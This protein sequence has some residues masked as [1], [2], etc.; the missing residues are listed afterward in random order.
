MIIV[1]KNAIVIN[2]LLGFKNIKIIQNKD[3]FNFSLDSVL[4]PNFAKLNK[5]TKKIVDLCTGNAPIPLILSTKTDAKITGF[6][7]QKEI[8]ELSE[9]TIKLNNLE[10]KIKIINDDIKNIFNYYKSDTVDLITCN[11]PYF[12][13][14]DQ[15]LRNENEVKTNARHETL[16]K[17]EDI[18]IISRKLLKNGSPLVMVHRTERL[19]EI[20]VLFKQNNIEPKRVRFVYPKINSES[21][22]VLIEG[23]KNGRK[24]MKVE[25]PLIVHN[26]N[27]EYT[28]EILKMFE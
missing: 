3:Y 14:N 18:V 11:P 13:I 12:E 16:I 2:D 28:E 21:N 26:E 23:I 15:T 20:I 7:I 4:V 6:E 9:E 22:L 27:G 1:K 24:G 17:L 10:D 8:Y 25:K 19:S 5:N